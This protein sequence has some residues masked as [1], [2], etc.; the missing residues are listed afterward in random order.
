MPNRATSQYSHELGK[1]YAN[2]LINLQ[3]S[4]FLHDVQR[5]SPEKLF[6]MHFL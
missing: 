3:P 1:Y 5:F 2:T 6:T 4:S